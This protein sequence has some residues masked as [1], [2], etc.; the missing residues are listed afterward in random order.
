MLH[1]EMKSEIVSVF[2]NVLF[3]LYQR[4]DRTLILL[5][6]D[7]GCTCIGLRPLS[8]CL[9]K[10]IFASGSVFSICTHHTNLKN[11]ILI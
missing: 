3:D 7:T 6:H 9:T 10:E 4:E 1:L 8:L 5:E 11:M 2:G